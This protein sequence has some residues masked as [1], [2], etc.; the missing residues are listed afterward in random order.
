MWEDVEGEGRSR[1]GRMEERGW[2]REDGGG[3]MEG[4]STHD[5]IIRINMA[6]A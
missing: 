3:R 1:R 5:L 4:A 6:S 2:R